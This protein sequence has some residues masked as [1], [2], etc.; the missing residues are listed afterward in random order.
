[1]LAASGRRGGSQAGVGG[2]AESQPKAH[3]AKDLK[4]GKLKS[5]GGA[6]IAVTIAEGKASFG[7]AHV[8]MTDIEATN[9]IVH[10]IDAVV[11]SKS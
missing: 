1:M 9:G 2:T 4:A 10:V 6:D 3:H 7:G 11:M 5:L 8:V